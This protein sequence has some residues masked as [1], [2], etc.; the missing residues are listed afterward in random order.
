MAYDKKEGTEK[1]KVPEGTKG[2]NV[3]KQRRA[4]ESICPPYD[5]NGPGAKN[6]KMKQPKRF[7]G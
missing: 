6:P 7:E 5:V 3:K 4:E 2:M 1:L